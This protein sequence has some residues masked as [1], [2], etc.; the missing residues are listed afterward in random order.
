MI[1]LFFILLIIYLILHVKFNNYFTKT[2]IVKKRILVTMLCTPNY[3]HLGKFSISQMNDYC[4]KH[5]YSL[6]ICRKILNHNLHVNFSRLLFVKLMMEKYKHQY[7]YIVMMDAD[8]T[9]HNFEIPIE[10]LIQNCSLNPKALVFAP[11]DVI[12]GFA[13]QYGSINLRSGTSINC[14]FMIWKIDSLNILNKFIET[15]SN[16]ECGEKWRDSHPRTQNVWDKCLVPTI[17]NYDK[18]FS[19]IPWEMVGVRSSQFISQCFASQKNGS[20]CKYDNPPNIDV[21]K[22]L[23]NSTNIDYI[24]II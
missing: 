19:Y 13:T 3:D 6:M 15:F 8:S 5:N 2:P 17:D 4:K 23:N 16:S 14:G 24:Q 7:D 18:I 21:I 9:V 20:K 12:S 10:H 1:F 11:E 22:L